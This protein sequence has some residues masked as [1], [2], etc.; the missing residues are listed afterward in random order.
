[1]AFDQFTEKRIEI[2]T[3]KFVEERR[4]P[5]EIRDQVDLAFRIEGQSVL[6]F[7]IRP[8]W[9]DPSKKMEQMAAKATFV[10]YRKIWKIYWMR[11]DLKWHSYEPCAQ[12]KRFEDFIEA[13]E[14]DK[15]CCFW[16]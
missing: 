5:A 8:L 13:I 11:S 7:E 14:K 15:H 9:N 12:V 1:M 4:P 16:G 2:L 6:I 10:A 3:A